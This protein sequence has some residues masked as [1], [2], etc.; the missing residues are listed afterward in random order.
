LGHR[1]A[2]ARA[3]ENT[4]VS[5]RRA[6]RD[7]AAGFEFDVRAAGDGNAF[8]LHDDSFDRTTNGKGKLKSAT[9]E[10]IGSLDAGSS[11][12]SEFAGERVPRLSEV[13]DEFL[14]RVTLAMEMKERLPPEVFRD[15]AARLAHL[16]SP[17]LLIASFLPEAL[18]QARELLPAVPRYLVLPLAG[19]L[20][21][22]KRRD[23]LGLRGVFARRENV[24][25]RFA[26]DCK[27]KA[28]ELIAYTVNRA[29]EALLLSRFGID[30]IISDDPGAVRAALTGF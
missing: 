23:E 26:A 4:L 14:G 3:P 16:E 10:K 12:S 7:G 20:P 25:P 28:L 30:G 9:L 24:D 6:L 18:A 8:V 2:A 15:L 19:A 11:F 27:A 17:R 13:F 1:G 29:E 22:G 5:F 21:G